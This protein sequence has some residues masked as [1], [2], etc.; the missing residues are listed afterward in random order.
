MAGRSDWTAQSVRSSELYR[1][2]AKYRSAFLG[3]AAMS[4][5]LNVLTLSG[6]FFMLLVYDSVLP[7]RSGETLVGLVVLVCVLYFFQ[8]AIDYLRSRLMAHVSAAA[9]A[10]LNHRVYDLISRV[11]VGG[12]TGGDGLLPLRDLDQLRG[13]LAGPGPLAFFDLPWMT[14]YLGIC[15]LFHFAIGLTALAGAIVLVSLTLVADALTRAPVRAVTAQASLRNGLAEANRQNAEVLKALGMRRRMEASWGLV[16]SEYQRSQQ[17][18]SGAVGSIGSFTRVLRMAIQSLVLAVG[19]YLVLHDKATGGVI[20][21]SSI[22]T[23]RALAPVELAIANW[24]GFVAARQSWTRLSQLLAANPQAAEPIP[25]P[26][27]EQSLSVDAISVAPPGVP[28]LV[29]QDIGFSLKAGDAL[30]IIGASASGKSSLARALVGAW[31]P[32]RGKV[33]LDGAALDQWDDERLGQHLGYL[34]QDVE[35]MAGS[36]AQNISRF[37]PDADPEAV[38]AAARLAGMH[39]MIKLLPDGYETQVGPKGQALSAG[40]AQR[41]GLARA[42]YGDPFLVVLDEPNSNLDADGEQALTE[43]IAQVRARGGIVV[44]VA[45]RPSALSAVDHVLVMRDGRAQ[46]FGPKDEV[47]AKVLSPTPALRPVDIRARG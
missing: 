44:V 7:S 31:P 25:L 29:I 45:H 28:R 22:L 33:R 13:F 24:R 34:P 37:D 4:S 30:G 9:D 46:A 38:F 21:T 20:I 40:Q 2:L 47:L 14:L 35:L 12:R 5:V 39:E 15:F 32:A 8:G 10:A 41:I 1:A 17:K 19:A 16:N 36:I 6:S 42:L 43:A 23:S 26:R 27:P 18:A 3:V 11:G